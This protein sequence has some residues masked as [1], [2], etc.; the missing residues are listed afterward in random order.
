MGLSI[1]R[2]ALRPPFWRGQRS[3]PEP[4]WLLKWEARL[5]TCSG[6]HYSPLERI[7]RDAHVRTY[8]RPPPSAG[9]RSHSSLIRACGLLLTR[10]LV[11]VASVAPA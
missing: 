6:P 2:S 4:R 3:P 1:G 8:M 10:L 9:L 11:L 5:G 7:H